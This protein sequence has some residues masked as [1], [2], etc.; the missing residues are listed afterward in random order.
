MSSG[1]W[2]QVAGRDGVERLGAGPLRPTNSMRRTSLE[3]IKR[4]ER[5]F[6]R[7]NAVETSRTDV[8]RSIC[9]TFGRSSC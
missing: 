9:K 2:A 4:A 7:L 8:L 5:A 6:R 3:R 1:G